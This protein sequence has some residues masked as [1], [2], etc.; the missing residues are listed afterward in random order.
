M[1]SQDIHQRVLTLDDYEAIIDL[2]QRAGLTSIRPQGRDSRAAF[3]RQLASGVQ[4]VIGLEHDGKLVAVIV[5]TH[6]GRKGWLNRLAVDPAYRRRG[7]ARRLI[8]AAEKWLASQGIVV[9]AALIEEG[10]EPSLR[11][12]QSEGYVLARH[13]LY[14]SK[15]PSAE[16]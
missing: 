8:A 5:A 16:A 11:L 15:R 4:R 10:N 3:A 2:W 9:W 14:L 7:L 13:I 12:F 1:P 6:D